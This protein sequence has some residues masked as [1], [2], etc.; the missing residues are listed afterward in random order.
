MLTPELRAA[1]RTLRSRIVAAASTL[2]LVAPSAAQ[3]DEKVPASQPRYLALGSVGA[4]LR[5][6]VKDELGQERL[7]PPFADVLLG[8]T[9]GANAPYAHGLGLGVSWNMG[10]DGGYYE[11]VYALE[12]VV[13]M[14][15][16]VGR[17]DLAESVP[18]IAHLGVPFL[19][20]GGQSFGLEVGMAIGYRVLAGA[21]VFAELSVAGYAGALA[22]LHVI[23]SLE[24]GVVLEYE[25]LP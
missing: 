2:A 14:P 24:A 5:V 4:P 7:G 9:F 3:A 18:L 21:G 25:V 1:G 23:T 8:Y 15:A 6:T 22:A 20:T 11:P 10:R 16:Y 19:V 17:M 12:Q 13:L